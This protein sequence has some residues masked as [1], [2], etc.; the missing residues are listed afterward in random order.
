M[1]RNSDRMR[2]LV[3]GLV[4]LGLTGCVERTLTINTEPPGARVLLND[5]EVGISPVR[6]AFLWYGDYDIV[7]RK[8]GYETLKTHHHIDAPWYQIAPIDFVSETLVPGTIHDDHVAPTFTLTPL[9]SPPA[10]EVVQRAIQLR[11]RA[12]FEGAV[13]AP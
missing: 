3:I 6:V 7:L 11:E 5:E 9:V 12:L 2:V 8:D 13:N 1:R 4:T 10:D